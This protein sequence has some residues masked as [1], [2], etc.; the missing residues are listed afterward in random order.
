MSTSKGIAAIVAAAVM[1]CA[2]SLAAQVHTNARYGYKITFPDGWTIATE[3]ADPGSVFGLSSDPS[4][5]N[6]GVTAI[7]EP[8]TANATQEQLNTQMRAPVGRDFWRDSVFGAGEDVQF[9]SDVARIHPSGLIAQQ[10]I[11]SSAPK[12]GGGERIKVIALLMLSP[13]LSYAMVCAA[14]DAGFETVRPTLKQVVD[15]F[16]TKDKPGGSTVDAN[17][18]GGTDVVPAS[19]GLAMPAAAGALPA[20]VKSAAQK[21][22]K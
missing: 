7:E 16:R 1:W 13:G 9:E 22:A 6:C 14:R 15:S 17:P 18:P 11:A 4:R 20:L 3:K 21:A 10:A 2:P 12:A 8:A 19:T 5:A